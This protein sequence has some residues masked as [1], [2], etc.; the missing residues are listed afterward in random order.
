M[1]GGGGGG[2]WGGALVSSVVECASRRESNTDSGMRLNDSCE[3]VQNALNMQQRRT[4]TKHDAHV[5]K[6]DRVSA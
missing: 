5:Q 4:S 3:A 1:G 2:G 6:I